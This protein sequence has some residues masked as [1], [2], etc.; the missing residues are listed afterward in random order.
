MT[1][2]KGLAGMVLLGALVVLTRQ[3]AVPTQALALLALSG[4]IG[5]AVGDT[6]F[7]ASLRDLSPVTIIIFFMLGQIMTAIMGMAFLHEI[8]SWRGWLGIVITMLGVG[9]AL[10]P[11]ISSDQ[12]DRSTNMRGMALGLLSML[13]MSSAMVMIKPVL[14]NMDIS[15]LSATFI[16]M[17]AGTSGIAVVGLATRQIGGWML[18]FRDVKFLTFFLFA[19]TIVTLGGFW[20]SIFAIKHVDVAIAS[21]LSTVEPLFVLPL[22]AVILKERI[23]AW[24]ASGAAITVCGVIVLCTS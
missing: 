15:T 14:K 12:K 19:V 21:T 20:L 23:N 11:Q 8:L 10:W 24:N 22:A 5:I 6:L 9:T 1:L 3:S 17:A 7:F 18:P 13:C 16:R 2:C 4:V